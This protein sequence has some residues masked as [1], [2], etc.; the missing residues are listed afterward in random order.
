MIKIQY[1][2]TPDEYVKNNVYSIDCPDI[3]LI[4]I[5]GKILTL[6]CIIL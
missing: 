6:N 4:L 3:C 2:I 1:W 5:N